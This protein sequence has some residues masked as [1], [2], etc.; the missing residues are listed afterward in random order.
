MSGLIGTTKDKELLKSMLRYV[1]N[2]AVIDELFV[3]E[4]KE[5][6]KG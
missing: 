4:L 1:R 5:Q 3:S 2:E 6:E